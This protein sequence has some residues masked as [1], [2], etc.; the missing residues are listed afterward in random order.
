[1]HHHALDSCAHVHAP[2]DQLDEL[3]Q[4]QLGRRV[5]LQLLQP[6][7]Q[8]Y[9]PLHLQHIMRP[10]AKPASGF[11]I[12]EGQV[13]FCHQALHLPLLDSA[14]LFLLPDVPVYVS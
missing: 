1:M 7:C 4:H 13:G 9:V 10:P 5:L 11:E 14:A 12:L 2:V 3:Q 8:K 6:N